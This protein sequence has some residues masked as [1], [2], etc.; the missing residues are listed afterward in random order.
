MALKDALDTIKNAV[1][2]FS[3]LTVETY[4]GNIST[5]IDNSEK[6]KGTI[7]FAKVIESGRT[8]GAVKLKLAS[9]YHF[10]GDAILFVAEEGV[11]PD[12]QDAHD[13][14]VNAGQ[15][16]RSDLLDLFS[17]TVKKI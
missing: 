13:R 6:A 14:A 1:G 10:D 3:S 2:D 4:T 15:M 9:K 5:V 17:E 12:L 16:V 11:T 7:D 8:D